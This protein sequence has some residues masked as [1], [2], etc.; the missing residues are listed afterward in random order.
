[1]TKHEKA[2]MKNQPTFIL[3]EFTCL[4]SLG[5]KQY[6]VESY[7]ISITNMIWLGTFFFDIFRRIK[8]YAKKQ[9]LVNFL[10]DPMEGMSTLILAD[11]FV[12]GWI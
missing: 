12:F 6:I 5:N 10:I 9:R 2:Y 8:V 3:F 4:D 7:H 1:M 11:I